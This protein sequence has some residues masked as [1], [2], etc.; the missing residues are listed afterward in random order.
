MFCDIRT[1]DG[2]PFEGDP[3]Q[4]LAREVQRALDMGYVLNV[5]PELEFFYFKDQHSTEVLDHGGHARAPEPV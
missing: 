4:V 2:K 1:P 5:G 3:R